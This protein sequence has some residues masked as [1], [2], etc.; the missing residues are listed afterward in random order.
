MDIIAICGSPR[1]GNTEFTLRKFLVKAEELGHKTE[2]VLLRE[3][4]IEHCSGCLDCDQ[5]ENG[6]P[7]RD[8]MKFIIERLLASDFIILGSPNY[9]S[10]VSGLMKNFIDRLH[11]VYKNNELNDKKVIA[12][13]VGASNDVMSRQNAVDAIGSVA[14]ALK[15]NLAGDLYIVA[16]EMNDVENSAENKKQID[17]FTKNILS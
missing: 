13:L 6:C 11:P 1:K 16:R 12:I 3:K 15:M 2:L 5:S 4:R 14:S 7:V 8:D 10:N 17:D 9:F